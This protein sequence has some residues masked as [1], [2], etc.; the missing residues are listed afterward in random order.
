ML[1][2]P[3]IAQHRVIGDR[4]SAALVSSDGSLS[5]LCLPNYDSATVFASLLDAKRGGHWTLGPVLSKSGRQ[6]YVQH[7]ASVVTTWELEDGVLE[8]TDAMLWPQT[9]RSEVHEGCRAVLR[10]L[11]CL[12]GNVEWRCELIPRDDFDEATVRQMGA[13]I[14]IYEVL[15]QGTGR[16][17]REK[18]LQPQPATLHRQFRAGGP[19]GHRRPSER[20]HSECGY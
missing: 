2:Y 5:W 14:E 3:P 10:R 9:T 20:R 4:R 11:R 12:A 7:T 6:N 19:A 16:R 8:L 17:D 15:A 18:R 13:G 1:T